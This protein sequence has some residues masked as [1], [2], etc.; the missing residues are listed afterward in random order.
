MHHAENNM[1]DDDSSTMYY[2]RDSLRSFLKHVAKFIFTGFA[3][4]LNYLTRKNRNK[5]ARRAFDGEV[6]F[7]FI[8]LGLCL[9]DWK[10]TFAVFIFT[11]IISRIFMMLGNWVQHAFIDPENPDDPYKSSMN[12]INIRHNHIAWNNG[13]HTSH[14]EKPNLHYTEHPKAFLENLDKYAENRAIVFVGLEFASIFIYLTRKRYDLLAKYFLNLNNVY[15]DDEEIM[16]M[17][18]QRTRRFKSPPVVYDPLAT[19]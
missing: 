11:F 18:R 7:Y 1:P 2:Q 4:L 12:C 17:L 5:L 3:G 16:M 14:H 6:F 10:A 8:C 15:K 19:T 13:Y 9:V